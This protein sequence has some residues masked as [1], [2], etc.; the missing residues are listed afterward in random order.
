M[1]IQLGKSNSMADL[2]APQGAT[3]AWQEAIGYIDRENYDFVDEAFSRRAFSSVAAGEG[4][5]PIQV[6]V[7][8]GEEIHLAALA[9][10]K[11]SPVVGAMFTKRFLLQYA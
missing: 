11:D 3:L 9:A 5:D 7:M 4:L 1:L 6:S 2:L 10:G 8:T